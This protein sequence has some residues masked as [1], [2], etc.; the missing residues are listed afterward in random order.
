M[1][2][3][4][5][6]VGPTASGKSDLAIQLAKIFNGEII[7]ADSR[8][9][10]KEMNIGT[11]KILNTKIPHHLID[12]IS[13]T[14]SFSAAQYK[15]LAYQTIK[16]VQKK[17]KLPILCGGTG[18]YISSVIENWQF[19]KISAQNI[20]R[21]ELESKSTQELLKMYQKLDPQGAQMIDIK[22]K[23]RLIRAIEVSSLSKRSFWQQ[24]KKTKSIFDAL[25]IGLKLSKEELKQRI[26]ERTKKMIQ[27]GLENEVETLINKYGW[28]PSL[29]SIGYQEWKEYFNNKIN[30]K[31]VQDL[32]ELHTLQYTKRQMTWFKKMKK[33]KWI[34][35]P[36]AAEKLTKLFLK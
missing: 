21:K 30:K 24:R 36:K 27:L 32:I 15:E 25:V 3:L 2:K 11:A 16:N 8:Q 26:E 9:I 22:N 28:I 33:I 4:L 23:R 31:E 34:E 13:P 14:E 7:S 5:V 6:I 19:P 12:I 20:L 17:E 18:L 10:F 1:N 29:Q 35:N